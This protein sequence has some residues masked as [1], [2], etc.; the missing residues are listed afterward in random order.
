MDHSIGPTRSHG[1]VENAT[2]PS[3]GG[4]PDGLEEGRLEAA[5]FSDNLL[6]EVVRKPHWAATAG[7][8]IRMGRTPAEIA[9]GAE[10]YWEGGKGTYIGATESV[11]LKITPKK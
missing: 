7:H 3:A 10:V 5:T 1:L 4:F 6:L 11:S 8:R 2:A 9:E